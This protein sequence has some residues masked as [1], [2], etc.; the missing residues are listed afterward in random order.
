[1]V[2]KRFPQLL[3]L[4]HFGFIFQDDTVQEHYLCRHFLTTV[5]DEVVVVVGQMQDH[6]FE[7]ARTWVK[8]LPEANVPF[9]NGQPSNQHQSNLTEYL[10]NVSYQLSDSIER[11]MGLNFA[12][13]LYVSGYQSTARLYK[14]LNSFPVII[15]LIPRK[16]L[17]TAKVQL[18]DVWQERLKRRIRKRLTVQSP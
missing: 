18:L 10:M 2:R 1:M 7:N 8:N 13:N 17:D 14:Y 6:F 16:F 4:K 15:S 3:E 11:K 9:P 12:R 5:L